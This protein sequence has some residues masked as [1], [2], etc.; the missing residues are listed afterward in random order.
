MKLHGSLLLSALFLLHSGAASAEETKPRKPTEP[1]ETCSV[2]CADGSSCSVTRVF[3]DMKVEGDPT[4]ATMPAL[5]VQVP[6]ETD[7][8]M[9]FQTKSDL[10][11]VSC[12]C[13]ETASWGE[14]ANCTK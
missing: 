2:T 4:S 13:S 12:T 11:K 7:Q 5:L 3:Y 6:G 10:L 9:I 8:L 14:Q 1:S